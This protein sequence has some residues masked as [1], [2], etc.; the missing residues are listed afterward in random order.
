MAE[1]EK[2]NQTRT[3]VKE[4]PENLRVKYKTLLDY[5]NT[6]VIFRFTTL[7]LY[8]AAV[9]LILGGK[10][11][12]SRY[13]L[14]D[15]ITICIYILEIRNRYIKNDLEVRAKKIEH[16]EWGYNENKIYLDK[17]W[18]VTILTFEIPIKCFTSDKEALKNGYHE[19][20]NE[21]GK[22]VHKLKITHSIALDVLYISIFIYALVNATVWIV[23]YLMS[24]ISIIAHF[25]VT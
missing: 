11:S 16:D 4:M 18:P 9:G 7:S 8:L 25:R 1:N 21:L 5:I 19:E 6:V 24:L 10:A 15:A 23:P 14:L 22:I 12:L 17:P 13:I 3:Q 20:T 2:L